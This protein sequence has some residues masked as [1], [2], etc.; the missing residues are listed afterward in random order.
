MLFHTLKETDAKSPRPV[1]LYS[2]V[3]CPT[4]CKGPLPSRHPSV[5]GWREQEGPPKSSLYARTHARTLYGVMRWGSRGK[6]DVLRMFFTS[7]YSI[8]MR[9]RP[10]PPPAWGG[11]P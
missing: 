7:R 5:E 11:T 4:I 6:R 8:R 3:A 2:Q 9:S 10:M 1:P